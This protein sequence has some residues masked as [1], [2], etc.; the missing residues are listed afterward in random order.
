MA[1]WFRPYGG[2]FQVRPDDSCLVLHLSLENT[3]ADEG[4]LRRMPQAFY[5]RTAR[6]TRLVHTYLSEIH[7]RA[8]ATHGRVH[9][10]SYQHHGG[11]HVAR[12]TPGCARHF[13]LG[14]SQDLDRSHRSEERRVGKECR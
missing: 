13:L 11:K 10:L 5:Y 9:D 14:L 12:T 4:Q 1:R 3:G 6:R 8:R 7:T 2:D